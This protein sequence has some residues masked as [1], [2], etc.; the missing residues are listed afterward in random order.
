MWVS[1]IDTSWLS[2]MGN[3][4]LSNIGKS[5]LSNIGN[6]WLSKIGNSWLSSIGNTEMPKTC[7]IS[8]SKPFPK[9]WIWGF[10]IQYVTKGSPDS[11]WINE[12][13]NSLRF[14]YP[15]QPIVKQRVLDF[16]T[17]T[18]GDFGRIW[19]KGIESGTT[20]TGHGGSKDFAFV[21]ICFSIRSALNAWRRGKHRK[22]HKSEFPLCPANPVTESYTNGG[23]YWNNTGGTWGNEWFVICQSLKNWRN[24]GL[25]LE[26]N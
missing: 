21:T 11:K 16:Y 15:H 22:Y 1:N 26:N 7:H 6:A 3:S 9:I 13:L 4:W 25:C 18:F 12:I 24:A 20:F 17:T 5:W 23:G 19:L 14:A 2:N 10:T 8:G